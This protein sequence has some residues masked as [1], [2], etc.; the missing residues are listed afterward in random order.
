MNITVD[1]IKSR[2]EEDYQTILKQVGELRLLGVFAIGEVLHGGV[3]TTSQIKTVAIFFPEVKDVAIN[4]S[5]L[6]SYLMRKDGG[7]MYWIDF[8]L[9]LDKAIK[10][11]SNIEDIFFTPYYKISPNFQKT[12]SK[13]TQIVN[14]LSA[15]DLFF[16]NHANEMSEWM[17]AAFEHYLQLRD[18]F[19]EKIFES[20]TKTEEKALIFVLE[21]IGEEGILSISEAIRQSGISRPVF[22]GLLDKLDRYKGAEVKNMGVKGTYISFH[23]HILSR[24]EIT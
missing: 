18:G 24:F 7:R 3:A 20:L 6:D 21:S 23:D 8:R 9:I 2:I 11:E 10:K 13:A 22:T 12:F 16:V 14:N 5:L 17:A 4:C 15:T 19:S 1:E